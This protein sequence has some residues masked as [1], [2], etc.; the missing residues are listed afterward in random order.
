MAVF[1]YGAKI[2][3]WE[4]SKLKH[5]DRKLRKT[6]TMYGSLHPKTDVDRLYVKRKEGGR[7]LI[8]L[9]RCVK[10]VENSW[11]FYVA[12]PEENLIREGAAAE[13]INTEDTIMS[14]EF[15]KT[16]STRT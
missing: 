7:F 16:E 9:E 14:G 10:E 13:A 6:M 11:S 4:E 12:N 15:K 5:V 3:Q 8:N 1:R 2:L